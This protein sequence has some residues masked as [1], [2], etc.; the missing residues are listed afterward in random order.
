MG[1]ADALKEDA[2]HELVHPHAASRAVHPHKVSI[3]RYDIYAKER[4]ID[5]LIGWYAGPGHLLRSLD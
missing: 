3:I 4:K 5:E 1:V 2:R